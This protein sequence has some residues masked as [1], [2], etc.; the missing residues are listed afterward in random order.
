MHLSRKISKKTASYYNTE[1][2]AHI[3]IDS[4]EN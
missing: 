2:T 3:K 1:L 4:T